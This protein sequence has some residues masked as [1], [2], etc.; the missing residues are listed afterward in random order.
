[1]ILANTTYATYLM[2]KG[3]LSWS[4]CARTLLKH[5]NSLNPSLSLSQIVCKGWIWPPNG[6][7]VELQEW[8]IGSSVDFK[9]HKILDYIEFL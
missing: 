7:S 2:L 5:L 1:M 8:V 3:P 6:V 4:I 9:H